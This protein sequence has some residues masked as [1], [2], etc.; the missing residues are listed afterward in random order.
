MHLNGNPTRT[1]I[2]PVSAIEG[3]NVETIESQG[4]NQ[5]HPVQKAW[6]KNNVPQCGYCQSGQVMLAIGLLESKS[7]WK[8][9][10]LLDQMNANLCR[11]G[12]YNKIKQSVLE[13]AKE[14]GKLS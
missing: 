6:I 11:C 1:C 4:T 9:D 14:M 5:L 3:Q 2:M 13:A 10:E 8:E 7:S 12:T